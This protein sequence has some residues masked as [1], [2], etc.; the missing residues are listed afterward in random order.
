LSRNRKELAHALPALGRTVWVHKCVTTLACT[1][2]VTTD[3]DRC[4]VP[5]VWFC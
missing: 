2:S 4:L 1:L 3:E 5:F